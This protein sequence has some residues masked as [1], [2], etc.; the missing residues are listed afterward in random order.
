MVIPEL[1]SS[2]V[3]GLGGSVGS[4][5]PASL[6]LAAAL[7]LARGAVAQ[8]VVPVPTPAA[9]PIADA[10]AGPETQP[11]TKPAAPAIR[12]FSPAAISD[13]LEHEA[14]N[15]HPRLRPPPRAHRRHRERSR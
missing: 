8:T 6:A 2:R 14:K 3:S 7:M 15:R 12:V 9:D 4:I 13:L 5:L 10:L 1:G 11:E